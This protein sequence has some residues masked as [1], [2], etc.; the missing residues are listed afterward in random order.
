MLKSKKELIN[1]YK[2]KK[3]KMG[4]YQIRNTQNNEL[5]IEGSTDLESIWNRQSFQLK[6][7]VHRNK[8]LQ[9]AWN[10]FGADAFTFEIISEIEQNDDEFRDYKKEVA[11]LAKLYIEDLKPAY[12]A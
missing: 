6:N 10:E 12:N 4:V 9:S 5:F 7:K 3:F 1:E 2:Q 11:D 8:I